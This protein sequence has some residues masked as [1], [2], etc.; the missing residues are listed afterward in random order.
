MDYAHVT[1]CTGTIR[2]TSQRQGLHDRIC[3][4]SNLPGSQANSITWEQV[5]DKFRK[6]IKYSAVDLGEEKYNQT[7]EICKHLEE[8]DDMRCLINAMTP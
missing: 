6:S 7:I 3:G 2:K 4:R 8:V 5:T 1:L